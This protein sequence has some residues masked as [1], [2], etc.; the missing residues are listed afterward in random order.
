MYP[1]HFFFTSAQT[2]PN[3]QYSEYA[4][5]PQQKRGRSVIRIIS[6]KASTAETKFLDNATI[7]FEICF[8][9]VGQQAFALS[10]HFQQ[11]TAAMM[12]R[13]VG[14]EVWAESVDTLSQQSDL[15]LGRTRVT[16]VLPVFGDH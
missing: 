8:L 4:E 15:D 13:F 9:Q 11:S 6:I 12:V 14:F 5:R 2:T 16:V 1:F 7:T 10:N 3:K